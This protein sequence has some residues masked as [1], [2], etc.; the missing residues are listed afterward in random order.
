MTAPD[1]YRYLIEQLAAL[2]L[3][4]IHLR[5]EGDEALL[6]ELRAAWRNALLLNR[7]NRSRDCI[8]ADIDSGLADVATLGHFA[9][10]N[11]DLVDRLRLGA[12]LNKPQPQ[13]FCGGDDHGYTDYPRLPD[14]DDSRPHRPRRAHNH[15]RSGHTL[16]AQKSVQVNWS[17]DDNLEDNRDANY[18]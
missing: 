5:V 6:R 18:W 3:A 14:P 16:C 9:L 1:T 10:A 2:D 11:P 13:T 8:A 15:D 12:P 17:V 4:Y 7:P